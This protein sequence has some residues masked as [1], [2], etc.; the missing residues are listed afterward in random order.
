MTQSHKCLLRSWR[1]LRYFSR[2]EEI[3]ER[4][5]RRGCRPPL[6]HPRDALEELGGRVAG[7]VLPRGLTSQNG[8]A[9]P[10]RAPWGSKKTIPEAQLFQCQWHGALRVGEGVQ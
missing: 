8:Q 6:R 5:I 2:G 10:P 9:C 3:D 4:L 1:A 7:G